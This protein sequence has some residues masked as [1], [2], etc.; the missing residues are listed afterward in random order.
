MLYFLMVENDVSQ[1]H[2]AVLAVLDR[3]KSEEEKNKKKKK[4]V[5]IRQEKRLQYYSG[6]TPKV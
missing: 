6:W 1:E 5:A 2:K 4:K 3:L